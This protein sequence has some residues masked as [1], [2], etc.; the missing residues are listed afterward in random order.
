MT[1]IINESTTYTVR[2]VHSGR[3]GI[4]L[5][6]LRQLV[7]EADEVGQIPGSARVRWEDKLALEGANRSGYVEVSHTVTGPAEGQCDC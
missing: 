5:D 7:Q 2:V 6:L 3:D 1:K 4:T